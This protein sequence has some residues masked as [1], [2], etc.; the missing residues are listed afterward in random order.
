MYGMS[1]CGRLL[2]GRMRIE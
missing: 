2:H 1:L